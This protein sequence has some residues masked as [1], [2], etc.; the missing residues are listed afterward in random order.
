MAA[1]GA[2]AAAGIGAACG[3]GT[4]TA[5]PVIAGADDAD[6][7]L[8][9]A[10]RDP[11]VVFG[12]YGATY[13]GM[14]IT[15]A[16]GKSYGATLYGDYRIDIDSLSAVHW[17]PQPAP[18][19][20]YSTTTVT[21]GGAV[22]GSVL[23]KR[24]PRGPRTLPAPA[25]C[26]GSVR[27][28][29]PR[30]SGGRV[31]GAVVSLE[32]IDTGRALLRGMTSYGSRNKLQIGGTVIVRDCELWPAVQLAAPIGA[33]LRVSRRGPGIDA[34][35]VVPRTAA[36]ARERLLDL[37]GQGWTARYHVR[38]AGRYELI[39][40]AIPSRGWVVVPQHPYYAITGPDGSFRLD[41][42]PPGRYS[43]VV[44]HPPVIT[45]VSSR[46]EPIAR[47]VAEVRRTVEIKARAT[48]RVTLRL[49]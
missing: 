13:A 31:S 30:I 45:G 23:W 48:T 25:A 1:A 47:A 5:A 8:A 10:S 34:I 29:G 3:A 15:G 32:D 49:R 27:N 41:R 19:Q 28:R 21:D 17:A 33:N 6:G 22:A 14:A 44:W 9:R 46:G 42:V 36:A 43:L 20:D 16:G 4:R 26:G 40:D 24:P 2:I 37:R 12:G 18:Y 39:P 38:A 7:V 11:S 35:R